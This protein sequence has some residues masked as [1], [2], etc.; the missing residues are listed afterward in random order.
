MGNQN[1]RC[2]LEF[3]Q[4]IGGELFDFR[5]IVPYYAMWL[6]FQALAFLSVFFT[7]LEP[8]AIFIR[9]EWIAYRSTYS[10]QGNLMYSV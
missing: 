5:N 6:T 3:Y 4:T 1:S 9:N 2:D 8:W 10:S 7:K